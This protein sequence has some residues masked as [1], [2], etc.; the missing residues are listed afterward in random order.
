MVDIQWDR[1]SS[2]YLLVAYSGFISLWDT[3]TLTEIHN[4]D[5]LGLGITAIAWM[6]WTVGN[7]VSA[8][9]KNGHLKVWNASQRHPLESVRVAS[10]GLIAVYF[11]T[12]N[13]TFELFIVLYCTSSIHINMS[14]L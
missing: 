8:S 2:V 4:F 3:E 6:D 9:S 13:V 14:R 5:K 7:F 12:G 10:A 1:L 11:G